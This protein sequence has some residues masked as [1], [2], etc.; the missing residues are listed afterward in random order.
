MTSEVPHIVFAEQYDARAVERMRSVGRVTVLDAPD[1][2]TL[3][4]AVSDCDALL[5]RTYT[6]V[7]RAVIEQ[8][9]RLRVIGRGGVGLDNID[10][11]AV[12]A[13]GITVVHTPAAATD[14]TADLTVGLLIGLL[15]RIA[16]SDFLVRDS[17]FSEARAQ[18]I[19]LELGELTLGIIG[20]GRIGRAVARR[21][22][23][24]FGMT[25]LYNDIVD[26]GP[27]DFA[28]TPVE[29]ERLYREADVVSL[30]VPL[31]D[32]TRHLIND[33]SLT[34]F[35]PGALLIN[36]ARG[37]VVDPDALYDALAGGQIAFA[38]LDVTEP[39]PLPADSPL[40]TL[41]NCLIAPHIASS[42]I[43]TRT[44]M[45]VM[46]ANNLIAGLRGE[47]LP[48]CAN[49]QVYARGDS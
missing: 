19:G 29:K 2:G 49:P 6:R 35:K 48:H 45:A 15:R 26:A 18:S 40:L 7:T 16:A 17:R 37:P 14:A 10:L 8:A 43:G 28:A 4:Q 24:G 27:L 47:R 22:R 23:H 13:R 21:C 41:D 3:A 32:Q 9:R 44:R 5:V 12:R 31:T 42:T 30:H 36:T 39:E 1:E 46:T 20:L 25:I 33:H 11:Q 34:R 38:A